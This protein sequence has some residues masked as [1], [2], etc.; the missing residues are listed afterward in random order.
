MTGF[1]S[2]GS[3]RELL[4]RAARPDRDDFGPFVRPTGEEA[5]EAELCVPL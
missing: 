1:F 4:F 3:D 2:N 5:S